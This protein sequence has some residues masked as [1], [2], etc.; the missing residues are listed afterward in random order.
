MKKT[1]LL[2]FLMCAITQ[3]AQSLEDTLNNITSKIAKNL[4][5][6]KKYTIAVYP[7]MSLKS[8]ETPLTLHTF[9]EFHS[10]LKNKK[11]FQING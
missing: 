4:Q 8:Q 2:I 1:L 9:N 6:H 11:T 7:F 5:N 3:T 10:A